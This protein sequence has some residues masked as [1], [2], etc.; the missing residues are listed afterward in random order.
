MS[1]STNSDG[2]ACP[3]LT[4]PNNYEIWKLRITV[5]LRREKVLGTVLGTDAKPG[6][7]PGSTTSATKTTVTTIVAPD[8]EEVRKWTERDEKAHGIIQDHISDAL[9]IKTQS[10]TTAKDLYDALV[11]LHEDAHLASAFHLYQQMLDSTWDGTSPIGDHIAGIRTIESWLAGMKYAI[12]P[13]LLA[14]TLINSLPKTLEWKTF[15]SAT[16]NSI[17]QA[18]LTFNDMET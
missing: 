1:E 6:A 11:K 5:K 16:I 4:R 14:F 8:P 15:V 9:L 7:L 10:H 3:T 2:T 18:K 12:D 13:R 17:D